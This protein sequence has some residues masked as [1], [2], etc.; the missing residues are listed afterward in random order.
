MVVARLQTFLST[1]PPQDEMLI[2]SFIAKA[3][4]KSFITVDAQQ[5]VTQVFFSL[6]N[7][8]KINF[9]KCSGQY[10]PLP[11]QYVS[12]EMCFETAVPSRSPL[13]S[14]VGTELSYHAL[15][16]MSETLVIGT[17]CWKRQ[18]W[19]PVLTPVRPSFLNVLNAHSVKERTVLVS[20]R[21]P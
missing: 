19:N 21:S 12:E 8:L 16:P 13:A 15:Q 14:V 9:K 6:I 5:K 2:S 1:K 17:I 10:P 3:E 4:A 18:S 20:P 7:T 11:S